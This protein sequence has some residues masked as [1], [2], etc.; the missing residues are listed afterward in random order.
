MTRLEAFKPDTVQADYRR[1]VLP[2][3]RARFQIRFWNLSQEELSRL[4][5]CVQLEEGL[6]H[7]L[8]KSRYLGFGSLRLSILPE[9]YLIDWVARYAGKSDTEWRLPLKPGDFHNPKVIKYYAELKQGLN[10]DAL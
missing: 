2:G 5:W 9:S 3:A 7:K 8:G 1:A 6:A 4:I 10:A